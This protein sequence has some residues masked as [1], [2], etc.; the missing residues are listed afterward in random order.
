MKFSFARVALFSLCFVAFF[1]FAASAQDLDDVTISGL[2]TDSNKL[3]IVGATVIAT[4]VSSGAERTVTT[5]EQ[6]RYKFIELKPGTYK[7]K[8]SATG[9]G[10][11]ER[12]DIV[13]LSGQNLQLDLS[14]GPADIQAATTVTVTDED[15]PLIDTTRTVVG[16]TITEREIEEI[17]NSSRNP[18]DLVLTLGGTSEEQLS[19]RDL[20]EDRGQRNL[21]APGTTPEEAGIFG[22]SGG[23]AYSNNITIDGL[24]NNDDRGA[25]FRFQPSIE[26]ISEVQVITNQF[27]AEYGRASGGRINLRTRG[28]SNK[29]RGRA[30]YFFR[31]DA[32]NANTWNNNRNGIARPPL[33]NHN[34]GFTFGGPIVKNKLF[35]FTSYEY[36]DIADTTILDAWVPLNFSNPNFALPEPT[37]PSSTFVV[38]QSGNSVTLARYIVPTDTPATKHIFTGRADW[39]INDAQNLMFSYQLGR[40]ND[41]RAFSGTN[42]IADSLIGR[43]RNTDAYNATHNWVISPKF[44]NQLRFQYSTLKPSAAQDAGALS[45]AVL[46]SFTGPTGQGGTQVFGSSTNSSD[47]TEERWQFQDTFS[48][49][50]GNHTLRFGGDFQHIDTV[51]TDRFDVTGTYSFSNFYFFS[52]NSVSSY[53]QNFNVTSALKNNYIGVFAQDDWRA[54]KNLTI[55]Y[56]LRYER[57]T[58]LDDTNNWGPRFAVAWNPF[59]KEEKTVIRFGA[60]I[61]YNRVLLRTI[62][63]Y[64][65]DSASLRLNTSSV[66]NLNVP[67]G[68]TVDLA[69]IRNF[70]STQFPKSLTA[71]TL[72]PV[73]ATQS[74]TAGQL[75]KPQS[76]FRSLSPDLV[77][78]ESYQFNIGFERELSKVIVFETNVTYNKTVHLWRETNPNAPILPSG[79]PDRNNDGQ[80]TLTDYLL[81][82]T[83]GPN[84]F[85]Q[86][87]YSDSV[88][89]HISNS[90]AAAA[91]TTSSAV[92]WVNVNSN[93]TYRTPGSTTNSSCSTTSITN[94]PGCRAFSI[95]NNATFRPR[96]NE[97]GDTQLEEVGPLGNSEYLG[98]IFELRTRYRRFSNGF[99]GSMRFVYTLSKLMDDGIVNTS[100]PSMPG[101]F[102]RDWSRSLADRRHRIAISG[103]FDL[104]KWLGAIRLSPLFRYGSSAP[105]NLS[106]GGVDRNLDDLSND[107]P[108]FDGDLT[109]L[110]WRV[111]QSV[112]F[113]TITA[114]QLHLAPL[115]S[116]GNLPRN[117][118]NGPELYIFDLSIGRE[119]KFGER[120]RLRPVAEFN[121]ILNSTI[122]SFGSNFINLENVSVCSSALPL[123]AAQQLSCGGFL[124]PTRTVAP[125]RVRLGVRFDF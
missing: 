75:A 57:E 110:N 29:F 76:V 42:R 4:E 89:V 73:N 125:R 98:A 94:S 56:G 49:L 101:D 17:P 38:T 23:A 3:P 34:P 120:F 88:G 61:F 5:N 123:T 48:Y 44:V 64:T 104:P 85:Y 52:I 32:L 97:V 39:N 72:I 102:S 67:A 35:F 58:V 47:R 8:A 33:R 28:G 116:P 84:R 46:V 99:G 92:C 24:D 60:G 107:R 124:A 19:T 21:T 51:Y 79:T 40:S 25:S 14:L 106:A 70:L 43:V 78:P 53:A 10:A 69:T 15:A 41:L 80:T 11:K 108:S 13:T 71:D 59:P 82:I 96:F 117:A 1:A 66:A 83:T 26:A 118:G 100:D 45:S 119:F 2:I 27:S 114:N 9:F 112:P 87:S 20:A 65:S 90:D 93:N 22:L 55:S 37:D 105:F 50:A 63:D 113:P 36:D 68:V 122:Y 91:C 86:G 121:N 62:D 6:G 16:G 81:G 103:T 31:D 54:R 115:G 30:F 7:V 95:F 12:I 74:F 18:L 109:A 111:F 77:I